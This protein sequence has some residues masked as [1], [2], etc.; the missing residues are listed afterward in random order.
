[1]WKVAEEMQ[2]KSFR[3]LERSFRGIFRD[4]KSAS[5]DG[6][7]SSNSNSSSSSSS[8][9]SSSSGSSGGNEL[10]LS[11]AA[12][13]AA[14]DD[15]ASGSGDDDGDGDD[16]KPP[17]F[18]GATATVSS[19]DKLGAWG[20]R[21]VDSLVTCQQPVVT[22]PQQTY[23]Q[24]DN[25]ILAGD[26]EA[27]TARS[28]LVGNSSISVDYSKK[29]GLEVADYSKKSGLE[30]TDYSK[31]SGGAVETLNIQVF[32]VLRALF[33]L[34]KMMRREG[35]AYEFLVAMVGS[36]DSLAAPILSSVPIATTITLATATSMTTTA[37]TTTLLPPPPP[38][39]PPTTTT[40]TIPA[41]AAAATVGTGRHDTSPSISHTC[42]HGQIAVAWVCHSLYIIA[43][44]NAPYYSLQHSVA[45][46]NTLLLTLILYCSL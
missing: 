10:V 23:Q 32:R 29:S 18:L 44:S 16:S 38:P 41:A 26:F 14:G 15:H 43:P 30:D 7:S 3:G 22:N 11:A 8:S 46:S 20:L 39:P 2:A 31:K 36:L 33:E 25:T 17:P 27:D 6:D 40:A 35:H 21:L 37:S 42:R 5:D 1:M 4:V 19:A 12:A 9:T 13:T 34:L 24:P 45:L 28:L